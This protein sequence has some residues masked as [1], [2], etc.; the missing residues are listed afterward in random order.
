MHITRSL[1]RTIVFVATAVLLAASAVVLDSPSGSFTVDAQNP[2]TKLDPSPTPVAGPQAGDVIPGRYLVK[3][4]SPSAQA[5]RDDAN[6][7]AAAEGL[8]V[9]R[10]LP[11]LG[12]VVLEEPPGGAPGIQAQVAA[13]L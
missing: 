3:L 5:Q 1:I 4:G 7:A 8:V 6:D 13:S 10:R 9:K 11:Q 12:W 2:S